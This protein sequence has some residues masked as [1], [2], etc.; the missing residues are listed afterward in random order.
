MIVLGTVLLNATTA[1]FFAKIIGV[2]LIKSEGVLI[3][4]ASKVS[5]LLG[6]YLEINGRHVVLIDSNESNIDKLKNWVWKQL[7]RIFTLIL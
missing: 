7:V 5:R 4:G 3:L 1:R 6:H 2:F